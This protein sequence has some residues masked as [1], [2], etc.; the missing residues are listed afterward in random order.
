MNFK[1][2]RASVIPLLKHTGILKIEDHV[3]LQ[4]FL[5]AYDNIR[6]NLPSSL[7]DNRFTFVDIGINTKCV[8]Y[9]QMVTLYTETVL[10]GTKSIKSKA[11]EVWNQMNTK[12]INKNNK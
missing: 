5:F 10:Y 9:N 11:I 3:K 2:K 7:V 4:N 8:R 6:R 12:F 1:S